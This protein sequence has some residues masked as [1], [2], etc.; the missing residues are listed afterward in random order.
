[1]NSDQNGKIRIVIPKDTD[2]TEVSTQD[3][4]N[5]TGKKDVEKPNVVK[6]AVTT[7]LIQ[8]GQQ[9]LSQG[10]N[11]FST[12]TGD[13]R[14]SEAVNVISSVASDILI[15]AKG[16][17]V[18]VVVVATKKVLGA[19]EAFTQAHHTNRQIAYDNQQLG[20]ISKAGSRYW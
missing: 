20:E 9:A 3:E 15:I 17:P 10:I 12:L 14:I 7:A 18:G 16:G 19:V 8:S 11:S 2:L 6:Q 4:T 5:I 1:M 13:Y